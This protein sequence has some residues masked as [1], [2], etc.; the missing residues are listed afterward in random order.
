MASFRKVFSRFAA[1]GFA[2][3]LAFSEFL[4]DHDWD[5]DLAAGTVDFGAERV[6]DVQLIGTES[7]VS[8]SWLWAWAN[9]ASQLPVPVLTLAGQLREFGENEQLKEL[10]DATFP[11][12]VAGGHALTLLASGYFGNCAYYRGPYKGGALFFLVIGLPPE[13]SGPIPSRHALGALS[14]VTAQ[15]DVEHRTLAE[16]LFRSE[17][18]VV[19]S[20][21][22]RLNAAAPDGGVIQLAFDDDGRFESIQGK[23]IPPQPG[24]KPWWRF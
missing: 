2:R 18:Y 9:D 19:D 14:Q 1:A 6:F 8:D 16:S 5:V 11:R 22:G 12:D 15:F 3:Q 10:T 24:R 17:N 21:G 20:I 7:D 4:G 13:V 23:G